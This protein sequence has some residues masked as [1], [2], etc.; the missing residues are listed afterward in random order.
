MHYQITHGK[1]MVEGHV[2]RPTADAFNF[3][4]STD[5][6]DRLYSANEM[7]PAVGDVTRQLRVL[8]DA[9][10][11]YLVLHKGLATE[12]QLAAWRAWLSFAPHYED[13]QLIVYRTQ[14]EWGVEFGWLHAFT[15]S[16]GLIH[17]SVESTTLR[18]SEPLRID[19]HWG[20]A[21]GPTAD[22]Q[23]CVQLL[24]A[25]GDAAQTACFDVGG[26]FPTSQWQANEVVRDRYEF[27]MDPFLP[28]GDYRVALALV[29]SAGSAAESTP[30]PLDL[31]TLRVEPLPRTFA[32]PQPETPF[33]VRLGERVRLHGFD[34]EQNP[35]LMRVTLY[36]QAQQRM[37]QSY[38][39]FVHLIDAQTGMLVAQSDGVPRQW[40]YPTTWWEADEVVA[41][42]VELPLAEVPPGE[43]QLLVGMYDEATGERL[44]AV[45]AGERFS[46]DAIPLTTVHHE[47]D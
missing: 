6:L 46:H 13:A 39:V 1:P 45:A 5:F 12:E 9:D 37:S 15:D 30:P 35:E 26:E 22:W 32:E 10:V 11:R 41:D 8:A 27:R 33:P 28:P 40:R 25:D 43:Y 7:D 44:P 18:Q 23:A 2:S 29:D 17:G 38:K 19:A 24:G 31:G 14:P 3:L 16:L 47:H 36:W 42:P 34:L 4:E 21:D 20:A